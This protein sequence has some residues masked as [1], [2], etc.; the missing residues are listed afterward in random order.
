M[1]NDAS[2][3]CFGVHRF[4]VQESGDHDSDIVVAAKLVRGIHE[5]PARF[6]RRAIPC[7]YLTDLIVMKTLREAIS[8]KQEG[9]AM[10]R[11][12][13]GFGTIVIG[14]NRKSSAPTPRTRT[15][16]CTIAYFCEHS[17]AVFVSLS[18]SWQCDFAE[19]ACTFAS[20]CSPCSR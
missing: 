12:S 17:Q 19:A 18:A 4:A 13:I 6:L 14:G 3:L 20:S 9:V 11:S 1:C 5:K 2:L 16:R 15:I 10:I 8:T 7:E